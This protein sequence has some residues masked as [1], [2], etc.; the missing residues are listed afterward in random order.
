MTVPKD[1]NQPYP[2]QCPPV[3]IALRALL[4]REKTRPTG[5]VSS[6]NG[7]RRGRTGPCIVTHNPAGQVAIARRGTCQ[8]SSRA[9]WEPG[10]RVPDEVQYPRLAGHPANVGGR[11][12]DGV[13]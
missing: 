12:E 3:L 7:M 6:K 10:R 9:R 11:T 4:C 13:R 5:D 8:V 2:T 1:M